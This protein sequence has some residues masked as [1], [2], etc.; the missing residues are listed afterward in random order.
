[1]NLNPLSWPAAAKIAA[2]AVL[3]AGAGTGTALVVNS[4]QGHASPAAKS[5]PS[6]TL[7]SAPATAVTR[8]YVACVALGA[9]C[10][11][12]QGMQARPQTLFL[13]ADGSLY[14]RPITWHGWE[15]AR[16]TGTA[17]AHADDC[18]PN[19]A[20]GTYST[21]PATI[22]FTA[23]KPWD[24]K[25]AY[26]HVQESVPA[27]GWHYSLTVHLM[28]AAPATPPATA[29]SR[30]PAPG[31]VSTAATVTSSCQMGY[32]PTAQGAVFR[33]GTPQGQTIAG[34]YYPAVP[35]Y[36]LTITGTSNA[37]ADVNGF[38]VVFYDSTGQELGS[39]RENVTETFITTGQSLT[40]TEYSTTDTSGNSDSFGTATIATG[41]KTC[42]MVAWYRS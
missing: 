32:I 22:I 30:P 15:T 9:G 28:P 10:A 19:C 3:A 41:A 35:G 12:S 31:P 26:T 7:V 29:A 18:K 6:A 36:Q 2:A 40:W 37:T 17:T 20:Q 14:L 4:G 8:Q 23:P 33:Q 24:G 34:T 21:Y 39:D 27:I 13:S 16:A 5:A 11:G 1:M 25:M 38:A 42:Q